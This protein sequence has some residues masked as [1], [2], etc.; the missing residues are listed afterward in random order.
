MNTPA[1][2]VPSVEE[3]EEAKALGKQATDQLASF[4]LDIWGRSV[5]T[6]YRALLAAEA[7]EK[8]AIASAMMRDWRMR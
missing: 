1:P 7:G 6:L 4:K 5:I 2:A 3:I 8:L